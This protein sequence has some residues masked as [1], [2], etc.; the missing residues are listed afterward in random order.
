[1]FFFSTPRRNV[2]PTGGVILSPP[3]GRRSIAR[4]FLFLFPFLRR[5]EASV[6]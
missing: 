4:L 3:I 1:L 2:E 5:V 6:L